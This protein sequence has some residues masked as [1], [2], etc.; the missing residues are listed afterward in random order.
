MRPTITAT[1]VLYC[2]HTLAIYRGDI[3]GDSLPALQELL[4]AARLGLLTAL[5]DHPVRQ[6]GWPGNWLCKLALNDG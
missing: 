1:Q 4:C 6:A 3:G 2:Q 5:A